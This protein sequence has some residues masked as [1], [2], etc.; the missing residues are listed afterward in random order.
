MIGPLTKKGICYVA[1]LETKR[2]RM[3]SWN[4][5]LA[6][7]AMDS[8]AGLS[9]LLGIDVPRGFPNEPVKNGVL[10]RTLRELECDPGYGRWS[11]I[12][13]HVSDAIV[14]GSMGFKSPP[15]ELGTVEIGY[16][17]IPKYQGQGYATEMA[18][19]LI[20][21]GFCHA[22]VRQVTAECLV[23]NA[24]SIRVLEKIGMSRV[25]QTEDMTRWQLSKP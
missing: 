11:G 21:W 25:A 6:L 14:I 23:G 17:I 2:L 22:G 13:V 20:E 24:P 9:R 18:R 15:D 5:D 1:D 3:I 7:A 19:G 4:R 12:I 8:A 10:P 16:D